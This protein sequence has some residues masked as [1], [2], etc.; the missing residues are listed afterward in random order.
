[1]VMEREHR[2]IGKLRSSSYGVDH[3]TKDILCIFA[4]NLLPINARFRWLHRESCSGIF[5]ASENEANID[6]I[7]SFF[8]NALASI[9]G[10]VLLMRRV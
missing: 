7:L 8:Y 6:K 1:M 5:A 2:S 3:R 4:R 10:G 9:D